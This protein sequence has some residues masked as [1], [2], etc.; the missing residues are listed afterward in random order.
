M[1]RKKKFK[2]RLG[3]YSYETNSQLTA[4]GIARG[5]AYNSK[6]GEIAEVVESSGGKVVFSC[7]REESEVKVRCFS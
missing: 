7:Q 5:L 2:A 4:Q 1:A 6:S 3:D